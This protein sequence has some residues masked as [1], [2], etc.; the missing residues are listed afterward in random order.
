MSLQIRYVKSILQI[1]NGP[2]LTN[3]LYNCL[4]ITYEWPFD[5]LCLTQVGK[6]YVSHPLTVK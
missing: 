4:K 3:T 1:Y 5:A 6:N 2:Y